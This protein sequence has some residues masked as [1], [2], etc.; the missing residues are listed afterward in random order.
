MTRQ[1]RV[2][3]VLACFALP[4]ATSTDLTG[5]QTTP[6]RSP[7]ANGSSARGAW[8]GWKSRGRTGRWPESLI[9]GHADVHE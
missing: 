4:I 5:S 7:I 2:V 3:I 9:E 6:A 8:H 1:L